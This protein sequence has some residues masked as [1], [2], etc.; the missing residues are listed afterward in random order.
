MA[1][2]TLTGLLAYLQAGHAA[3]EQAAALQH[4]PKEEP[5]HGYVSSKECRACHAEQYASWYASYHR[6]MT[7]PATAETVRGDFSNVT[8]NY[9]KERLILD[10]HGD[11]FTMSVVTPETEQP[12]PRRPSVATLPDGQYPVKLVTGSHHMQV[13]WF[14][15]G[16]GRSLGQLPFA[17]LHEDARWVPRQIARRLFRAPSSIRA[18]PSAASA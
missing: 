11:D 16:E 2:L 5:T 14:E 15:T 9:G 18:S 7:Q 17:Y 10:Q 1:A 4:V 12:A 8:L 6:T 13:Y 3:D